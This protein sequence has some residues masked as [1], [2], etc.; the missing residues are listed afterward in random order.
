[1]E[2]SLDADSFVIRETQIDPAIIRVQPAYVPSALA[3]Q[4][5]VS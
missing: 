5:L 1:M 2:D 3:D 4:M